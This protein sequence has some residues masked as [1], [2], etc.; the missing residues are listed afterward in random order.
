MS[1]DTVT[2]HLRQK[3]GISLRELAEAV[4][5]THQFV[6]DLELAKYIGQ[7]DFRRNGALLMQEAFEAVIAGKKEQARR[8]SEDYE[9]CRHRLLDF[10]EGNNEL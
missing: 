3:H 1:G 2:R 6:S 7:Y 10:M 5:V 8:L 4:G 9:S